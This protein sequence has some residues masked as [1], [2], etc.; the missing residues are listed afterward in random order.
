MDTFNKNFIKYMF[1]YNS[2]SHP[3][4]CKLWLQKLNNEP[5]EQNWLKAQN[6][7]TYL[8]IIPDLSKLEI[9]AIYNLLCI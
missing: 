2:T 8:H 6:I 9:L 5:D 4:I 7:L 1:A 3:N